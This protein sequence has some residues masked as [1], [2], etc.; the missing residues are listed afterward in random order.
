MVFFLEGGLALAQSYDPSQEI[1]APTMLQKRVDKLGRGLT[2]ILFGWTEIPVT[3]DKKMKQGKPLT[4]LFG[5]APVVGTVRAFMRTGVGVYE[6]FT[7]YWDKPAVS[8]EA[9]IEPE[10]VF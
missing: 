9:L 1:P 2:N 6:L 5:T 4:Y 3:W 7:F 10:Y 8:Y